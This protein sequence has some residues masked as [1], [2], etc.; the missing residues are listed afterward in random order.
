MKSSCK[1]GFTLFLSF[2][3]F[4]VEAK[5]IIGGEM[6]YDLISQNATSR[7]FRITLILFRDEGC[8][9]EPNC[10][11]M[12]T[13]A[14]IG[15]YNNDN[16]QPEPQVL[17]VRLLRIDDVPLLSV[18]L[19]ISNRPNLVY[20]AGYYITQVTLPNNVSG[21]SAAYQT[22]C[23]ISNIVNLQSNANGVGSTYAC[24]IP[25]PGQNNITRVDNSPRYRQGISVVCTDNAFTLDFSA[26]DPDGDSLVYSI[27]SAFDG[28][29]AANAN[30]ITP[31]P[32]PYGFLNYAVGYNGSRPLGPNATIN[33]RTGIISG[34]APTSGKYVVAVCVS[35]YR[36]RTFV[37][38]HRKDFIVSVADCDFAS[39]ELD[40]NYITCD[41]FTYTFNNLSNS[42]LNQSYLWNFNDPAAGPDSVSTSTTPTHTFTTPGIYT[43]RM[44]VNPNTPCADSTTATIRVFPGF[45]PDFQ[46]NS[47]IC[48]GNPVQFNDRTRTNH[49]VVDRWRWDFGVNSSITDTSNLQNPRF[50]YPDTGTYT[51]TLI[52]ESSLGCVD[53]VKQT[54]RILDKPTLF[55]TND[56]LMCSIDDLTLTAS[57][58][59]TGVIGTYS[60]SP[61]Y[62]IINANSPNPTIS[63]DQTT[64]YFVSYIDNQG[65][66]NRDSVL[67]RVVDT[68]SL[69]TGNDTTIC[70]TDSIALSLIS[71]ALTYQWT[72]AQSLNNP[73]IKNPL[74]SPTAATTIYQVIGNIGSCISRGEITVKTVAY[75]AIRV[76]NDTSICFGTNAF[77]RA[78]GG[79]IYQWLTTK[80]ISDPNVSNPTII[81][82][83][84]GVYHY[85][86]SVKD[87]FGCPLPVFDS[88]KLTVI[89]IIADAGPRDT[90]I[91]ANQ[92]LQLNAT[93][94]TNYSW[95]PNRWLNNPTIANPKSKPEGNIEY[96][97]TVSNDIGCQDTDSINVKFFNLSAGFYVP[98]AFSPNT[99][100]LNDRIRPMAL[101]LKSLE[102]F[103]IFNRWGQLMFTTSQIGAGWDGFYNGKKQEPG[104]YV[105]FAEGMVFPDVNTNVSV[106][107]KGNGTFILIR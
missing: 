7:T 23:R 54:I 44:V 97:V 98:N 25:G 53:T 39:A 6:F 8:N 73:N 87:T 55:V 99:D 56:T 10:A 100:G 61:N 83:D 72:P 13:S 5:H 43:I 67:V 82:P 21:Y 19:C 106:P 93:G 90:N 14:R 62:N 86:V 107:I 36:N 101:G 59:L 92:I 63:P 4:V 68:V 27:C 50:N 64:T 81:Q 51:A 37:N 22:C 48:R 71:D 32:P 20:K 18:P 80:Y 45:F 103:S 58:N 52:V 17:D 15:I 88:I 38:T 66:R 34:I 31:S 1:Y 35:A 2:C 28:G 49:G 75:P 69:K 77:P 94:S 9:A 3:F 79:S 104:T 96:V 85:V 105:W 74:A 42:P 46:S 89:R 24:A 95:S 30:P 78:S 47:P 76:S 60:W 70:R 26:T 40:P 11:P 12:P 84:S 16:F 91:V 41:G 29:A 102:R 33:S 57:T 65:C